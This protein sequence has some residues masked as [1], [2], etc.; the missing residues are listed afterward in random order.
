LELTPLCLFLLFS[1]TRKK[2]SFNHTIA[3]TAVNALKRLGKLFST[4]S[5]LKSLMLSS[6]LWK[7]LLTEKSSRH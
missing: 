2:G 4:T 6:N 1:D 3:D 5:T 7:Y